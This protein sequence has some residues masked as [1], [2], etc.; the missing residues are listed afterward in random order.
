MMLVLEIVKENVNVNEIGIVIV[1]VVENV[2][3]QKVHHHEIEN[4]VEM[5]VRH[6][7]DHANDQ[8]E[9]VLEVVD[10]KTFNFYYTNFV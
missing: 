5:V 9:V 10:D 1:N 2:I 3:V 8:V 4:M 7:G 6:E